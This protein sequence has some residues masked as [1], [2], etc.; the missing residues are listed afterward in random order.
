MILCALPLVFRIFDFLYCPVLISK[1]SDFYATKVVPSTLRNPSGNSLD[2]SDPWEV[3][4]FEG[5]LIVTANIDRMV[6]DL[7]ILES[8]I[9]YV[10]VEV[11]F[12]SSFRDVNFKF[13]CDINGDTTKKRINS[14]PYPTME[15]VSSRVTTDLLVKVAQTAF[16]DLEELRRVDVG[17]QVS[18]QYPLGYY[19]PPPFHHKSHQGYII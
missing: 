3:H 8:T 2:K 7:L 17:R 4:K 9:W 16:I 6:G 1:L 14:V 15:V 5:S 18:D 11:E 13:A 12:K 19:P 10:N